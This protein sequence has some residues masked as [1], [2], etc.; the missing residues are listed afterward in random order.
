[1]KKKSIPNN[2][3]GAIALIFIILLVLVF[4]GF[5]TLGFDAGRWYAAK[6]KAQEACDAAVLAGIQAYGITNWKSLAED[7]ARENFPQGYL[8]FHRDTDGIS[9][10]G[11]VISGEPRVEGTIRVSAETYFGGFIGIDT[12]EV[13]VSCAAGRIPLE[14]MLVLD[15]SRSMKSNFDDLR[16]AAKGFVDHFETTQEVDKMGLITY[17]TGVTVD[18]PLTS[19]FV[20][21]GIKDKI[22]EALTKE[23]W[24]TWIVEP[25][26]GGTQGGWFNPGDVDTNMEDALD[27]AD[28]EEDRKGDATTT[29]TKYAWNEPQS[30]RAKQFLIFFTNGLACAFRGPFTRNGITYDGVIPDPFNSGWGGSSAPPE[31]NYRKGVDVCPLPLDDYGKI[32]YE[33]YNVGYLRN[34]YDGSKWVLDENGTRVNV[35]FLPTGD[36]NSTDGNFT[37]ETQCKWDCPAGNYTPYENT[38]WH[39]FG[40]EACPE[41]IYNSEYDECEDDYSIAG[42][43]SPYCNVSEW[44]Y[45]LA[46]GYVLDT[47]KKMTKYHARKLKEQGI[48]IYCIGLGSVDSTFL[49][50]I[51]NTDDQYKKDP[52]D[53]D[54]TMIFNDIADAIK[55]QVHLL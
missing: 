55:K 44:D 34:P 19:N 23:K 47:C 46:S 9:I 20:V 28:D 16:D 41:S 36:G 37:E 38:R 39:V 21:G 15:R 42:Y 25:G 5:L 4:F 48:I 8:G 31:Y 14:I 51:A 11:T 50:K 27:Q 18:F 43:S 30:E 33:V 54:L 52:T 35:Y 1:M 2:Q 17:A 10:V 12:A 24:G 29:F 22:E 40:T 6:S 49:K 13:C 32:I 7:V 26:A 53:G 45:L 3:K